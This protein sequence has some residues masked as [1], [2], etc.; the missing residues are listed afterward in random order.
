MGFF[1]TLKNIGATAA[2]LANPA[3]G[4]GM[5]AKKQISNIKKGKQNRKQM[6]AAEYAKQQAAIGP[7]DIEQI[8]SGI[9]LEAPD[10]Q[11]AQQAS[12]IPQLQGQQEAQRRQLMAAQARSGVRGGGASAQAARLALGQGQQRSQQEQDI[13]L[14][15]KF[16]EQAAQLAKEQMA[17][18]ELQSRRAQAA[19]IYAA[20]ATQK[21]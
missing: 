7:Q 6:E 3:L 5:I 4:A 15:Q 2:G 16:M 9:K 18:Q 1:N 14:K 21:K 17:Q 20:R 13:F 12:L 19:A 8:R 10:L 11:T